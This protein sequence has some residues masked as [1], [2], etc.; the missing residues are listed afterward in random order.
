[1]QVEGN[2]WDSAMQNESCLCRSSEWVWRDVELVDARR[3]RQ[4]GYKEKKERRR[5]KNKEFTR[6]ER[7]M[8]KGEKDTRPIAFLLRTV[9][10]LPDF[11]NRGERAVRLVRLVRLG[12]SDF[13]AGSGR[14][15]ALKGWLQ[16][17][18]GALIGWRG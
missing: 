14:V 2:L 5:R 4:E 17:L 15:E 7:E 1:M 3:Q 18:T 12:F 6:R 16:S 9:A 10:R 8:W 13:G 11:C